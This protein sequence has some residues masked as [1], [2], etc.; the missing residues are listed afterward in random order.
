M[1]TISATAS[2]GNATDAT[3]Y[4]MPAGLSGVIGN[5]IAFNTTGGGLNLTLKL[6]RAGT[7]YI[8]T[9]V[10]TIATVASAYYGR[11]STNSVCPLTLDPGDSLLGLGTGAGIQVTISGISIAI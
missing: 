6:K 2:A 1:A 10:V 4:T 11:N 3:L 5:I 9:P 7:V 8:L